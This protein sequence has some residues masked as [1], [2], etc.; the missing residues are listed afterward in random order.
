MSDALKTVRTLLAET[1]NSTQRKSALYDR[2]Q[3]LNARMIPFAGWLMPVQYEGILVEHSAVRNAAGLFDLGHMGQVDVTGP[4]ALRFLQYTTT[5]DVA[6]LEPGQAIYSLIPNER[7]GVIDDIIIYRRPEGEDGYMIVVNASNTDRDVQW[8]SDRAH[9]HSDWNV[10]LRDISQAISMIAIQGPMAEQIAQKITDTSLDDIAYFTWQQGNV[11]GV[12]SMIARTGYTGED[13]FEFYAAN[14][15]IRAIWDGL[16]DAGA[17]HGLQPVG[18]GARDTLRL[19]A[20]MPLYGQELGE[21]I[22]PYEAG[23][24]WAVSLDKGAFVGR[25]EMAKVKSEGAPRRTV[26]FRITERSGSPRPHFDVEAN[27]TWT[28]FVTSGAYSPTLSTNIGLALIRR[29]DAGVGKPLAIIIRD[30][31][32]SAVQVKTPFY[33]RGNTTIE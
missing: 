30:K 10:T 32:V 28:G 20:R 26:G 3:A 18:L 7:G 9:M 4:D 24:G 17:E 6:R 2:H 21:D 12:N 5:N 14:D 22:S 25:E 27:G 29:A 16:M 33:K 15:E 13:G 31:P 1:E 19:E 8:W 23:L 11:S